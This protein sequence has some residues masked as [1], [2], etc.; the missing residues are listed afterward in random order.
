MSISDRNPQYMKEMWGTNRLVTDYV[1]NDKQ[2]VKLIQEI[3]YDSAN[4]VKKTEDLYENME[5]NEFEYGIEPTYK[6]NK[7][8]RLL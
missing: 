7:G 3:V 2:E 8:Q 4:K 5:E 6:L 1:T